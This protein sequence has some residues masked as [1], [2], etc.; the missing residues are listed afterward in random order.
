MKKPTPKANIVEE[1]QL[2]PIPNAKVILET[3]AKTISVKGN[4]HGDTEASFCMIG[5]LWVAYIRHI[6]VIRG[7][8]QLDA[9]DVAQMMVLLKIARS[10]YGTGD[11]NYV[12]A[13]GYTAIAA[14]VRGATFEV[15]EE[16]D[17]E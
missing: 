15:G 3:A 5:E 10:A 13:A 1:T 17:G 2:S 9:S 6:A 16:G 14:A 8:I 12:D 7:H 4:E 11:D